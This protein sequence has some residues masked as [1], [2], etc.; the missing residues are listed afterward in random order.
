MGGDST[1]EISQ[2]IHESKRVSAERRNSFKGD[3]NHYE[4]IASCIPPAY[5]V[6]GEDVVEKSTSLAEAM[7][8]KASAVGFAVIEHGD[9]ACA[10]AEGKLQP[11][12]PGV[13][14]VTTETMFASASIAKTVVAYATIRCLQA[15]RLNV[16]APIDAC[17]PAVPTSHPL[18]GREFL[19]GSPE[20]GEALQKFMGKGI[21]FR[22]LLEHSSGVQDSPL[23]KKEE[24][25]T[26]SNEISISFL[27]RAEIN[28]TPPAE[29][30]MR[31]S[32]TGY[33]L[34]E[35]AL[36][37]MMKKPF[38][39][40]MQEYV[41]TPLSMQNSTFS[42]SPE[43]LYDPN[44]P[45]VYGQKEF[46]E[47]FPHEMIPRGCGGMHT[48]PED[49]AKFMR[50]LIRIY[51]ESAPTDPVR[52][53]FKEQKR[54][55]E[56]GRRCRYGLGLE[57]YGEEGNPFF[58][59]GGGSPSC[60]TLMWIDPSH[61]QGAIV[62]VNSPNKDLCE[63]ILSAIER[64]YQWINRVGYE[65]SLASPI[66]EEQFHRYIGEYEMPDFKFSIVAEGDHL[67]LQM[68]WPTRNSEPKSDRLYLDKEGNLWAPQIRRKIEYNESTNTIRLLFPDASPL[69]GKK[70]NS[71]AP[72]VVEKTDGTLAP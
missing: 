64:E 19:Y 26:T 51:L 6:L 20:V 46:G 22:E 65:P 31:Y 28:R 42:Q 70:V 52:E 41:L 54:N 34:I 47:V 13:P 58:G 23:E 39:K 21:T 8:D 44:R 16:D 63:R 56:Q 18:V 15:Q 37:S 3:F 61:Q 35:C 9:V 72:A 57:I 69:D 29:R 59:H 33:I 30:I 45:S 4:R 27:S 24:D 55:N 32:N 11:R 60:S 14:F 62:M 36:E 43:A 7:L 66:R 17:F 68:P 49:Y 53:M 5:I 10:G 67:L 71:M 48:S 38:P 25:F 12:K 40:I 2:E 1:A 50:E